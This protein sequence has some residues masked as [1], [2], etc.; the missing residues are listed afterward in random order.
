MA[1]EGR[2]ICPPLFFC[3]WVA[4]DGRGSRLTCQCGLI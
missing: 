1:V 2:E 4:P 3:I